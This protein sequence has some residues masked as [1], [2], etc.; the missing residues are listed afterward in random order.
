MKVSFI[1]IAYNEE[2]TILNLFNDLKKQSY[3]HELIEVILI[4][5]GSTD[6]TFDIMKN[7]SLEKCGFEK[8]IILNNTKKTLPCGW[9]I[10]IENAKG[11][12]IL[13]VDAHSS[14]PA[15]FIEKNVKCIKSGEKICGGYR[16]NIIDEKT[17]WKKTLLAAEES[18]FGSSIAS[19]R[20]KTEKKYVNSVFHGAYCREVFEKVGKYNEELARTE[21]NEMHYRMRKAGYKICFDKN[22]ISYQ[23][24][25]NT[26]KNM[27]KQKYANGYWIGVTLKKGINC[28][29]IYHFIPAIF[30]I[31]LIIGVALTLT[32][33]LTLLLLI[34]MS[35]FF[36]NV[37]ISIASLFNEKFNIC[38]I[39]LPILFFILHSA[40]GIGTIIGLFKNLRKVNKN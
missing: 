37:I 9:N 10:A 11:D 1:V 15:D 7:F 20:R 34:L 18:M 40:Y 5:G 3:P 8:V 6:K 23:H 32:G 31:S 12:I 29:S 25:R 38:K 21:D 35:Y 19:Y 14:I 33:K 30:V 39:F 13:R 2:K 28:F 17:L 36:V 24:T 22:I 4:D 16:P 27:L 26:F